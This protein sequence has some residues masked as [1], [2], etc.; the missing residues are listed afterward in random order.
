MKKT[1]QKKSSVIKSKK[2]VFSK[3]KALLIKDT[4]LNTIIKQ[5]TN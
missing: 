1:K 2:V 4:L 3:K 5:I